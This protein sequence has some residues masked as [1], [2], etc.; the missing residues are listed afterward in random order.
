[1][2]PTKKRVT[3][4]NERKKMFDAIGPIPEYLV[5]ADMSLNQA[6]QYIGIYIGGLVAFDEEGEP[7]LHEEIGKGG[8]KLRRDDRRDAALAL[9]R[10]YS[11]IWG[12]R[13]AAGTIVRREK[14]IAAQI[15]LSVRTVQQYIKDFPLK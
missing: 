12:K 2:M 3:K 7:Y 10:K 6:A 5:N 1:M 14:R 11:D 9:Q 4:Q 15:Q 8:N 13:G